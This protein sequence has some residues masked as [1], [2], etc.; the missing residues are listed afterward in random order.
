MKNTVKHML[1]A[2]LFLVLGGCS[3]I[4]EYQRPALPVAD[5]FASQYITQTPSAVTDKQPGA[6]SDLGWRDVFVNPRLQSLIETALQNNRNLRETA[7]T[8]ESFQ[9]QYRIQR[10]ALLPELAGEGYGMKQR[11]L[12]GTDHITAESY[13]LAVRVTS[14]E[15]DF[16]G[17]IRS[18]KDQ[19]LEQYLAM[20]ETHRSATISLI[21]EVARSYLIWL[22]DR[23]LLYISEDTRKVEEESY[24]L[25]EQRVGAGIANE[26]D[27]AQA[28]TSLETVKANLA[29]YRRQVAL[30]FH[31]LNLLAG[32]TIPQDIR[33]E[34]EALSDMAPIAVM[35]STLSSHVL[36]QR[37]DIIAAE[38][39][40]M[41]ANA[42]IGAA[43]AAFFP[44][45]SLS[46][47]V[48]VISADLGN[49][50]DGG[51]GL[52]SFSPS[53]SMPIFNAGRLQAEL[54][55][56]EISK[57]INVARYESA[58]QTAFREVS[59]ALVG[60]GTY[61]EQLHAQKANLQANEEY[62]SHA[63][64]RYQEGVDSFLTLLDAQRSLYSSR[65]DYLTLKLAQLENQVDLY[66]VLGGG[67]QE[68]TTQP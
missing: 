8:I 41:G 17:R 60:V 64:N 47:G 63:R 39:E 21:A 16:F 25:V 14:Y 53:V 68:L 55:V 28:R 3:L 46:A 58:I 35:P 30:D 26:M 59:D 1:S 29:K 65:Q 23:E 38:H 42:N 7:L 22:A 18:L 13:L 2:A 67:W 10:A 44:T 27:L 50:F 52:W 61:E 57:E 15:L 56:A 43:R 36:L 12:G 20:E 37:P 5:T 45:I 48:G 6:V 19:A 33:D 51:S 4:P 66:K 9:A 31:Y 32:A 49:L 24:K 54:N 11:T 34:A 62:F 40:L